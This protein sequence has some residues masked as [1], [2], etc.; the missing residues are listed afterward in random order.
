MEV[1][2]DAAASQTGVKSQGEL[3]AEDTKLKHEL[4]SLDNRSLSWNGNADLILDTQSARTGVKSKGRLRSAGLDTDLHRQKLK[5]AYEDLDLDIDLGYV[6]GQPGTDITLNSELRVT[7][8]DL[9]A[10]DRKIDI[11]RAQEL[12]LEGFEIKSPD[13]LSVQ[14]ITA[15]EL[16]LGRSLEQDTMAEIDNRSIFHARLDLSESSR[17]G[18]PSVSARP[19][20][21]QTHEQYQRLP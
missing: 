8:L 6:D 3:T 5:F 15:E 10:P 18:S 14:K 12:H 2:L 9:L 20:Q 13:H 19:P 7:D 1:T 16:D 21:P 17:H 11:V 4:A